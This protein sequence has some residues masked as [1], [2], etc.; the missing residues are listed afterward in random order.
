ME[1]EEQRENFRA[2]LG[3]KE[4]DIM[5]RIEYSTKS[6]IRKMFLNEIIEKECRVLGYYIDLVFPFHKLGLEI[7][8]NGHIDRLEAKEKER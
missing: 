5:Q 7:D 6:K 8:E 4:N 1:K 2:L 3:F